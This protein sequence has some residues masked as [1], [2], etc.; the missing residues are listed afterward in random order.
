MK[1][2]QDTALLKHLHE[3]RMMMIVWIFVCVLIVSALFGLTFIKINAD[4]KQQLIAVEQ[5]TQART[6]SYVEQDRKSVV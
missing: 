1:D 6:A 2:T 3:D 4:R 5:Q